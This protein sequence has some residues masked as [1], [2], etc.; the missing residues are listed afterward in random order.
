MILGKKL[1]GN[2]VLAQPA[3]LPRAYMACLFS[4]SFPWKTWKAPVGRV[5][6]KWWP[7]TQQG[8]AKPMEAPGACLYWGTA[9]L[10][11]K[12]QGVTSA[13]SREKPMSQL[14]PV[15]HSMSSVEQSPWNRAIVLMGMAE[16]LSLSC[17]NGYLL[18]TVPIFQMALRS[19]YPLAMY[20][21]SIYYAPSMM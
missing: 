2:L 9:P 18:A 20:L 1:Q 16:L 14:G 8:K 6:G 3:L 10:G 11:T 13:S 15:R 19:I 21:L 12:R 17:I 7:N 4:I 5:P